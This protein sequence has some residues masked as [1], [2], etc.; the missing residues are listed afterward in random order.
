M[1]QYENQVIGDKKGRPKASLFYSTFL[2]LNALLY[3]VHLLD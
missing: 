1:K 2:D 3:T